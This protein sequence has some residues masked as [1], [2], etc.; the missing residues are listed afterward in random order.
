MRG[1]LGG[2]WQ[3]ARVQISGDSTNL[4][5]TADRHVTALDLDS[6]PMDQFVR[7]PGIGRRRDQVST[8]CDAD[9]DTCRSVCLRYVQQAHGNTKGTMVHS[10]CTDSSRL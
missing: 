9:N 1:I 10:R 8:Y 3:D 2:R 6:N 7:R 5:A 4:L